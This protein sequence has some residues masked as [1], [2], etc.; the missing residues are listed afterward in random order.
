MP[1]NYIH[2]KKINNE[3]SI[4]DWEKLVSQKLTI[5]SS[6]KLG[7]DH[8]NSMSFYNFKGDLFVKL[9]PNPLK[10]VLDE[11][12]MCS[13]HECLWTGRKVAPRVI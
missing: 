9:W 1:M 12:G 3:L 7:W 5:G 6:R 11:T 10:L 13:V 8:G 4:I 2:G